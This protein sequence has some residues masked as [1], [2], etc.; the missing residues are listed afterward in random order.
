MRLIPAERI[1]QVLTF[2]AL[3]ASIR[4]SFA[5]QFCMPAR[6]VLPLKAGKPEAFAL[7]PAWNE[8]V[9]GCKLFTYFPDNPRQGKDRLYANILLFSRQHGEPLALLDGISITLWRT[10]AIS[11]LAASYL[12]NPAARSLVLFGT[13]RLAPYL[14]KAYT[15]IRPLERVY[16]VGRDK[17]KAAQ[18]AASLQPE[19]QTA[20]PKLQIEAAECSASL[21]QSADIICCATASSEPLF[22][23][24]WVRPGTLVDA[25]GNHHADCSEIDTQ[26]VVD[27]LL[28]LDS[29]ANCLNE[30]G[31]VLLPLQAGRINEQHIR[32]E[33]ADLCRTDELRWQADRILVFKA[34]GTA[35]ADL[36]A[37]HL[38]YTLVG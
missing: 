17:A 32:G 10:A 15:S 27:S 4:H 38:S 19:L 6:Q 28:Y 31:E 20:A 30:A 16:I 2:P 1:H 33:L 11:A 18:L 25:L 8:T 26:L 34:V 37:A 24:A 14:V 5:S 23:A 21:L 3:I 9:I 13:G 29:R 12:A 7:L 22:P 35:L 36:A